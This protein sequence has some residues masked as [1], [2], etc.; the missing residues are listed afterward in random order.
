M[1]RRFSYDDGR[2]LTSGSECPRKKRRDFKERSNRKTFSEMFSSGKGRDSVPATPPAAVRGESLRRER[3]GTTHQPHRRPPCAGQP[4][5]GAGRDGASATPPSAVRGATFGGSGKGRRISHTACRRAQGNLHREREG[6]AHQ[7]HRR[8]SVRGTTFI[9]RGKGRRI[10]HTAGRPCAG[11]P[12]S[13]AERDGASATPPS[14]MRGATFVGKGEASRLKKG[15]R[16]KRPR[17]V[18]I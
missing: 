14:I 13:G 4:S 1:S 16:R 5:S 10:S 12:S 8:P 7:P 15:F 11:R 2:E 3:E 9:G 6:T 18:F 17:Y